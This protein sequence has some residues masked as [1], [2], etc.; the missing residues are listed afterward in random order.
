MRYL[1]EKSLYFT[2]PLRDLP[3]AA[4]RSGRGPGHNL[5]DR[6]DPRLCY[7]F[8]ERRS[9]CAAFRAFLASSGSGSAW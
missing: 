4:P 1:G 8:W 6:T 3:P 2:T 9:R 5:R 7:T